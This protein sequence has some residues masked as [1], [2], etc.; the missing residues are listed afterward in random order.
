M[1]KGSTLEAQ[2]QISRLRESSLELQEENL[3]LK[4]TIK[5]LEDSIEMKSIVKW[6][7]PSYWTYHGK[8][9][10]GPFCQR[11]YD[12]DEKLIR[13]QGGNNDTWSCMQC[14]K[15]FRGP[16]YTA[17]IRRTSYQTL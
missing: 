5:R 13:L 15:I 11:C 12:S 14:E 8:E 9:K 10:D 1:K 4:Q 17:R 2:E 7:K 3:E 6:E 16:V